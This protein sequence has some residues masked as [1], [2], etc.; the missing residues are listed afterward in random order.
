M[1]FLILL[2]LVFFNVLHESIICHLF[3]LIYTWTTYQMTQYPLSN[4]F[5]DGLL[6]SLIILINAKT[7]VYELNSNFKNKSEWTLC[8]F[9]NSDLNKQAQALEA[10]FWGNKIISLTNL[11]Q[12]Y[13][14]NLSEWEIEF[15]YYREK[16]SNAYKVRKSVLLD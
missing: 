12:Q 6:L 5:V 16:C 13:I 7:R 3:F 14:K 1:H 11:L 15:L 2:F 9:M 10:T 8:H 4:S